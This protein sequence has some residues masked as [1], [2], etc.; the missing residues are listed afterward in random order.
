LVRETE[1]SAVV[2]YAEEKKATNP[3]KMIIFFIRLIWFDKGN[4][5]T[6]HTIR[7][8]NQVLLKLCSMDK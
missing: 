2:E 4:A 7:A 8:K 6:Y 5:R 3:I 1:V